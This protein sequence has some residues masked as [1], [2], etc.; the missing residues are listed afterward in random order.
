[1]RSLIILFCM[2]AFA[3]DAHW[4]QWRGPLGTGE[5]PEGRPPITWSETEHI[6]WKVEIPG[7]GISTPVAWGEHLFLTTAVVLEDR[8]VNPETQASIE[9]KM[10]DWVKKGGAKIPTKELAFTVLCL[11]RKTGKTVWQKVLKKDVPHEGT[12]ADSTW[13][14]N[15]PVTDGTHLFAYFG[16]NG[17]F[18]LDMDGNVLWEKDLGDM[19]TRRSFGEGSSPSLFGDRLIINWDHEGD[20]F[21]V[22]MEKNTGKEIWRRDRDEVTS[23]STPLTLRH[24]SVDQ[25]IVAACGKTRSYNLASGEIL[26]EVSG[27]TVNTVPTP[28]YDGNLVYVMSGFRGSALQAID[29]NKAKGELSEG[30]G[31]AWTHHQDTPYVPSPLLYRDRLYFLKVNKGTLT[32]LKTPSGETLFGPTRLKSIPYV[33]ASPVAA[34]GHVYLTSRKGTTLVL[35]AEDTL[36]IVAENVLDDQ[37]DASAVILEDALIL[38]GHKYLYCIG[39]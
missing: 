3:G 31:I 20:S 4:P 30:K 39:E 24:G 8:E 28:V 38:R 5:S 15:S 13:A 19:Q 25:V 1:M 21:I 14:S 2:A 16:S 9:E 27:M 29:L 34:N 11:D 33:Y 7:D 23:W 37:I 6:R 26:W 36:E 12:H 18:C 22:V 32:C 35:K 17:L 10:P